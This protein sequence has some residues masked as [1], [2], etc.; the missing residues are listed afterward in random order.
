MHPYYFL[1]ILRGFLPFVRVASARSRS[2]S[3]TRQPCS[4]SWAFLAFLLSFCGSGIS[5]SVHG[6]TNIDLEAHLNAV[7]A[8]DATLSVHMDPPFAFRFLALYLVCTAT[9]T[10]L[11]TA[12]PHPDIH[13]DLCARTVVCRPSAWR[14]RHCGAKVT[15]AVY[16]YK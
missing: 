12:G 16:I 14:L 15:A 3:C 13:A 7:F 5:P 1:P 8:L 11:D 10:T 2:I 9:V 4:S 6:V